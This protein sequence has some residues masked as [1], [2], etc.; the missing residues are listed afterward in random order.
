[1]LDTPYSLVK[2]DPGC[3]VSLCENM[4]A[5]TGDGG[6]QHISRDIGSELLPSELVLYC[7]SYC[8]F[9]SWG[10]PIASLTPSV[11]NIHNVGSAECIDSG[12]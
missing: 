6:Q 3:S 10:T 8:E 2:D 1:M 9:P 5:R 11:L 4:P 12:R 7:H